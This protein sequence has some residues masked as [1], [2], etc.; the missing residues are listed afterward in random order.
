MKKAF[1]VARLVLGLIFFVFGL[2]GF[3]HFL[4]QPPLPEPGMKFV[5]ALVESGYMMNLVKG[6]EVIAGAM[7]LTGYF[8]PL[9]LLI[10]APIVVNIFL[11]H[12][13]LVPSLPMPILIV[14]LGLTVAY[15]YKENFKHVLIAKK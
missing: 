9:A 7:L 3:L 14:I 5:M 1:L 10:L 6:L 2:N 4:P 11:F 12:T 8:V 15:E 13:V